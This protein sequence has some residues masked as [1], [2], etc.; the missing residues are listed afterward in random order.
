MRDLWFIGF[1]EF[2]GFV[3]LIMV[4]GKLNTAEIHSY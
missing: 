1:V 3:G 2:I 4:K